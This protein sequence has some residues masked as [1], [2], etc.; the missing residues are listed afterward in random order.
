MAPYGGGEVDFIVAPFAPDEVRAKVTRFVDLF[1]ESS[2]V[3]SRITTGREVDRFEDDRPLLNQS[4]LRATEERYRLL[5][6]GVRDYA[7]F[8]LDPLGRVTS[9]NGG[10][11]HIKGYAPKRS[12][13]DT[14]PSFTRP[15][16][17][18]RAFRTP[19]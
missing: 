19:S 13:A 16:I 14:S 8:G 18:L 10:A 17:W 6:A 11:Q 3:E 12:S 1:L 7:I 2:G 9:W 5:I 4:D 15:R